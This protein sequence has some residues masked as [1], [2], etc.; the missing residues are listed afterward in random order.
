MVRTMRAVPLLLLTTLCACSRTSKS[1][2]VPVSLIAHL[3]D[4]DGVPVPGAPEPEV[5]R[6]ESAETLVGEIAGYGWKCN[7]GL[8]AYL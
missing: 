4:A 7:G 8:H 2:S 6:L 5:V 1:P 3:I